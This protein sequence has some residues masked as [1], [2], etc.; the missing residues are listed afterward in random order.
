MKKLL[1]A[2]SFVAIAACSQQAEEKPADNPAPATVSNA[3]VAKEIAQST[4]IVDGHIDVPYRL[5]DG[6]EDV[7]KAT[8]TGDF[9]YPRAVAGGLNAPFM[10]IYTP[11]KF[12]GT[13][14][15]KKHADE[16]INIVE[17][18]VE[19]APD[20]YRI[21]RSVAEV[22]QAFADGVIALPLGME[23]GSP[24]MGKLENIDYFYER[25]IRYITL[26]HGKA[27][28]ISDS[29]YDE[30]RKWNGLSEFGV[31]AIERMN[32]VGIM[33]DISHVSDE[34]FWAALKATK[35]PP[36]ASHSSARHFTPGFERN[37]NDDMIKALAEAG[38][39]IMINY[40]SS[41]LTEEANTY[42]PKMA[43]AYEDHIAANNL[44]DT[45]ELKQEFMKAY[46]ETSPYPY[47]DLSDVLDHIDHAVKLGGIDAVGLGSDYD[48]VG[49]SLP[50][51]LKDVTSYP[52][53]V[54]GLLDRGYSEE[55][56]KKILSGN[57]FRVWRQ[58]EE[59]A[60]AN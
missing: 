12:D 4:I 54:E 18:I 13:E 50:T 17:K 37:M 23:N 51:G 43:K 15:A 45:P 20:K 55:D 25:G 30:T 53:L 49:D 5:A 57:L 40:G 31:Q 60:A 7:S 9:D 41:F 38:G 44:T 56:I 16:M 35:V 52:T 2:V 39:V 26:T 33:V 21:T 29:S 58:V 36:I 32:Q 3:E 59:Y 14:E 8:E 48:G 22:E 28:H 34:A 24:I 46:A 42:R 47:A 19:S 1:A 6:W 11:A 10:S 27:N